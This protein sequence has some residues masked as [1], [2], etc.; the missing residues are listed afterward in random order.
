VVP[1]LE[2]SPKLQPGAIGGVRARKSARDEA[3]AL[4]LCPYCFLKPLAP[5]HSRALHRLRHFS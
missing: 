4:G 5:M 1:R 2:P 3:K